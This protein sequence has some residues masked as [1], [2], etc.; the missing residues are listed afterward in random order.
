MSDYTFDNIVINPYKEGVCRLIGKEVYCHVNPYLCVDSANNDSSDCSGV[1]A[2]I[3]TYSSTPF[4]VKKKSGAIYGYP[5]IIFKNEDPKPKYVPFKNVEDFVGRYNT[6]VKEAML[7]SFNDT[8]F[9]FGMW[10][11]EKGH[12]NDVYCMVS[13][14]WND[15]LVLGS[16]QTTTLWDELLE[17]YMFLDDTPCGRPKGE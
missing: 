14:M 10:V 8:L 16:D 5:C 9:Q 11:K 7:D 3:H 17:D 12:E 2:E 4:H 1:L 6:I 15:G 13:E